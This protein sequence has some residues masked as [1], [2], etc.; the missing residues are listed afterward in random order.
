MTTFIVCPCPARLKGSQFKVAGDRHVAVFPCLQILD[1]YCKRST[2]ALARV[3]RSFGEVLRSFCRFFEVFIASETCLDLFGPARMRSDAIGWSR[4]CHIL[5]KP[6]APK[7]FDMC[8]LKPFSRCSCC[9]S[10]TN[11]SRLR[12]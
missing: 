4:L 3:L 5:A 9:S 12:W 7:I 1:P 10:R 8:A 6:P 11:Q 2:M